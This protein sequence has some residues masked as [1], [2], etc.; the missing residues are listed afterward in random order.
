LEQKGT[1]RAG[2]AFFQTMNFLVVVSKAPNWKSFTAEH[3]FG[4]IAQFY[5][6]FL[7][8]YDVRL[9]ELK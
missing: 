9:L 3:K 1:L 7:V 5:A 2:L 6:Y 4:K 8:L